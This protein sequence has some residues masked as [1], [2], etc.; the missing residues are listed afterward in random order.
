MTALTSGTRLGPYE[1]LAPLGTGGMGEVYRARDTRLGRNVAVKVLPSHLTSAPDLRARF[2]REA[3]AV[4]SLN[5]PHI[6]TLHDVGQHEGADYLVMELVEGETLADRLKKGALPL[7]QTLRSAI[8]IADAL[9]KAHRQGVIHR[10]LKPGNVMLTKAGS[11]LMDFGLAKLTIAGDGAGVVSALPTASAPLTGQGAILGTIPYMAPE[12]L[13]GKEADARSDLWAFGCLLYEMATG[14]RAF[15]GKSQASLISAIMDKEPPP[16][17]QLQPL[18][19]PPLERLVKVCL[20]KDP[21]DRFQMAHDVMQELKWIAE[22]PSGSAVSASGTRARSRPAWIL[23]ATTGVTLIAALLV[24]SAWRRGPVPPEMRLDIFTPASADPMSFAISPDG[25]RIVFEALDDG[26]S[27][28]WLRSLTTGAVQPLAGTEGGRSPF[29]SPDSQAIAFF[30]PNSLKRLDLGGSAPQTL[31]PTIVGRGGAWSANGL[32]VFSPDISTPL[33]RVPASGGEAVALTTLTPHQQSHR[34]PTFLPD[35]RRFLYYARGAQDAAG[36]YLGAYDGGAPTRL[37]P[38]DSGG[39]YLPAGWLL[40]V[41]AGTLIAQ[42]FDV[43]K[44]TLTG[45]PVTVAERVSADDG[46]LNRSAVSVAGTGLV[47]YRTGAVAERQLVWFDRSGARLGVVGDA[48]VTLLDPRVSPDGRRVVV[49]RTMQ[50]NTD[51]WLMDGARAS[52]F[53]YDP[54]IERYPLWSPDGAR[55]VYRSSRTGAGDLYQRLTSGA[56][57]EERL[58]ASGQLKLP[59]SW[60]PDGRFVLYV[61]NDPQTNSDLWLLPMGGTRTPGVFL[62]TPFR[63]AYAAFSP[64]GRWVAYQSNE[65]GRPEI[66]VRPF[67]PPG[68]ADAVATAPDRRQVSTAGGITPVWRKDGKEIYYLNPLGDMMAA[69]ITVTGLTLE[70]GAPVKLFST[71]IFG[72][73]WENAQG[74]QYDATLD[75]RFLIN[76]LLGDAIAPPITLLLN[77]KAEAKR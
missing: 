58:V 12:Q 36:I 10:D 67:V 6:C 29:W 72:G 3:K 4:S 54:A 51:L 42:R 15:E 44:A 76:A 74:P 5:H 41:R 66:Y 23:I 24:E 7:D 75:G 68:D 8:E 30:G 56:G 47:A 70:P 9:D 11:K 1:I 39:Y 43:E 61:S 49:A 26:G 2:E 71:R 45:E 35:G 60:S 52:R 18:T 62:K 48:D 40:W 57:V 64:D 13:E 50:G 37:T 65:S 32:I 55:I 53:T 28:L 46:Q 17:S 14:R 25:T 33:M 20:A 21:D 59:G 34:W 16:I 31:T 69:P 22:M 77:W 38:A 73:G 27:R 19:P 63:E